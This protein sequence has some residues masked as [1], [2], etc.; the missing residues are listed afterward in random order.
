MV[1]SRT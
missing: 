1:M